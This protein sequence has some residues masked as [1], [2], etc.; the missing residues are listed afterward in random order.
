MNIHII[1]NNASVKLEKFVSCYQLT[2]QITCLK[3][4]SEN[5]RRWHQRWLLCM[6]MGSIT[7]NPCW[8]QLRPSSIPMFV[9]LNII[10]LPFLGRWHILSLI[11]LFMFLDT[12][13]NS[14][15][16]D[17]I[18]FSAIN[19]ATSRL[20]FAMLSIHSHKMKSSSRL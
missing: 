11:M 17:E 2:Y 7:H 15:L 8:K 10:F 12:I 3:I 4:G 5:Y 20:R 18:D 16:I 19:W 6:S 1:E 14:I 9:M 13:G